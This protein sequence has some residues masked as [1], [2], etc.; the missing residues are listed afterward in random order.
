MNSAERLDVVVMPLLWTLAGLSVLIMAAHRAC[1]GV[2]WALGAFAAGIF[3]TLFV[4][5]AVR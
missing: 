5:E 3:A 2:G 4:L 1:F